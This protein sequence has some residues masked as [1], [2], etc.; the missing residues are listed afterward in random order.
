MNAISEALSSE[1]S[2]EEDGEETR[3]GKQR[4]ARRKIQTSVLPLV[5]FTTNHLA[6]LLPFPT[7]QQTLVQYMKRGLLVQNHFPTSGGIICRGRAED[8]QWPLALW[9]MLRQGCA[10]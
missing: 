4:I 6:D 10:Q 3:D 8:G 7:E 9:P 2:S 1:K 5:E